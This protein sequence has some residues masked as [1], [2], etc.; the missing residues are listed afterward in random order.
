MKASGL[1]LHFFM[2]PFPKA[3]CVR[4]M[5]SM[6]LICSLAKERAASIRDTA[7]NRWRREGRN[8]IQYFYYPNKQQT[9]KQTNKQAISD[10]SP[11]GVYPTLDVGVL[12]E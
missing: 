8:S 6:S 4:Q 10:L 3:S 11:V 12:E 2:S 9:N 1:I 7:C 5:R